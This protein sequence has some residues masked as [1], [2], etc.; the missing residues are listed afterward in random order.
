MSIGIDLGSSNAAA[1]VR[2]PEGVPALLPYVNRLG[3]GSTP[4]KVL[5]GIDR[6]FVGQFAEHMVDVHSQ[7]SMITNFKRHFGA[8]KV[9]AEFQG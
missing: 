5:L 7:H 2:L 8:T 1:A 3:G 9:L 4:T 6:A